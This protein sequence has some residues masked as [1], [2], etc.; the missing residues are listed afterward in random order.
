MSTILDWLNRARQRAQYAGDELLESGQVSEFLK[1]AAGCLGPY[2]ILGLLAAKAIETMEPDPHTRIANALVRTFWTALDGELGGHPPV[3][4]REEWE[5]YAKSGQLVTAAGE[6]LESGMDWLQMVTADGVKPSAEWPVVS[7]LADLAEKWLLGAGVEPERAH[8]ARGAIHKAMSEAVQDL[9]HQDEGV[10]QALEALRDWAGDEGLARL[11]ALQ[12]AMDSVLLFGETP[13]DELYVPARIRLF[14]QRGTTKIAWEQRER[15]EVAP[16]PAHDLLLPVLSD[17]KAQLVVIEGIMG[18]GKSCL[19]RKLCAELSRSYVPGDRA[20]VYVRWKDIYRE[21]AQG[22]ALEEIGRQVSADHQDDSLNLHD[23]ASRKN[24]T[25]LIDGF[26]EMA[27]HNPQ[28][29]L[30]CFNALERLRRDGR[31]VVV[32]TRTQLMQTGVW[33]ECCQ[34]GAIVAEVQEFN[35]SD[36]AAWCEN[37]SRSAARS[38]VTAE[39]LREVTDDD[40]VL[41]T[42]LLLYMLARDVAAG[43]ISGSLSRS[44][45]WSAFVANTI[46][47]KAAGGGEDPAVAIPPH[48]YRLLLQEIAAIASWPRSQ[49]ACKEA[50]LS[51]VVAESLLGDLQLGDL[52]TAFV[53]HFFEPGTGVREFEFQPDGFRQYLLAEWCVRMQLQT[54][55]GLARQVEDTSRD[56]VRPEDRLAQL[57][58]QEDERALLND[59]CEELG[60]LALEDGTAL[61][62]RLVA[63]GISARPGSDSPIDEAAASQAVEDLYRHVREQAEGPSVVGVS[64][65]T[66]AGIPDGQEVPRSLDDLRLIVNYWEQCLI[67]T[68]GLYRGLGKYPKDLDD[69]R[70]RGRPEEEWEQVFPRDPYALHRYLRARDAVRGHNWSPN[71]DLANL[72]LSGADLIRADLSRA[73]LSE[74]D[75]RGADLRGADL[76]R[77]DLIEANLT[78]AYLLGANLIG[79][80]LTEAYLLGA[81]LSGAYLSG[82]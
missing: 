36:L 59:L 43:N 46:R 21:V 8:Q 10:R 56:R 41:H 22:R 71:L 34:A 50:L 54:V 78:E 53:L 30:T 39:R 45:I 47:G 77:A 5:A 16:K 38:A 1:D 72:G 17:S 32:A 48:R 24:V 4:T 29:V 3:V 67:A 49:R 12:S 20:P 75:L 82:A 61:A 26:D 40:D 70:K 74:A 35:D 69:W 14:D 63:L 76:V 23:L 73:D 15:V 37:W 6:T 80:N 28:Y 18:V 27:S 68:F 13:Q 19:M 33:D 62:E 64:S 58:L 60:R 57:V 31:T 25:L 52:Q 51:E 66:R 55:P 7:R 44:Q 81:Y 11:A 42:P 9:R 79:A 2:G 65:D